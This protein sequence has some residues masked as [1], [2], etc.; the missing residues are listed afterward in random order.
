[1][2]LQYS[3]TT[4]TLDNEVIAQK[5]SSPDDNAEK[6]LTITGKTVAAYSNGAMRLQK[7]LQC[8]MQVAK[9]NDLLTLYQSV[10]NGAQTLT[11]SDKAGTDYPVKWVDD[12]FPLKRTGFNTAA[13]T[14][15]L[16]VV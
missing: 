9:M 10:G 4:I 16:E 12:K 6:H 13:G 15:T 1:M 14:I 11:Y 7:I 5:E 8:N 3:S 2:H